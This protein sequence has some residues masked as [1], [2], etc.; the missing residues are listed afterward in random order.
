MTLQTLHDQIRM[1]EDST[2][3]FKADVRNAESLAAKMV[4]FSNSAGGT[5]PGLSAPD[6]PAAVLQLL[7]NMNLAPKTRG[8]HPMVGVE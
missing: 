8:Y 4:A 1:G 7:Q 3:Q 5:M 2:R 6:A